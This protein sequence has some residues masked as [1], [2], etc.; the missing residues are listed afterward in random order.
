[1]VLIQGAKLMKKKIKLFLFRKKY[2]KKNGHNYTYPVNVFSL[3]KVSV[4]NYTYGPVWVETFGNPSE[5]LS[6]GNFCSL[7]EK[8]VFLLGGNHE[9]QTISTYPFSK[10]V[11]NDGIDS[12]LD[13][14][15]VVEDDVWIGYRSTILSGVR[16]G[17]GAIVAA[18]SVV[19]KDVPPYA[20]VG[21]VPA[22]VIKYRFSKQIINELLKLDFSKIDAQMLAANRKFFSISL[23]EDN[24]LNIIRQIN[25]G[26]SQL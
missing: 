1:M 24:F 3:S 6:I 13:G 2:K 7:A 8:T 4:G 14:E 18:G 19:T 20:I 9:Y 10:K 17:Q 5:H 23:N 21:G 15:I 11:F 12:K 26:N 16:I 22:K 25:E